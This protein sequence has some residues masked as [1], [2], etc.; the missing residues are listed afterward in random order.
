MKYTKLGHT[1]LDVSRICLGT[2]GFGRPESGM[3]PWAIDAQKSEKVVAKAL[4]LGI[5]FFDTANIYSHGDSERYLGAAL[6]KLAHRD[7]VVVATKVFYTPTNEPNQHGLSRK[8]IMTQID[9]SLERLDMDYIDLY[10]IH[11]WDYQTPIE[12]TMEALHDLVKAG[13]VRYIGASAMFA[14]QLE[15]AQNIAEKHNWTKFVSM[16]NHYNLLYREDERELIPYCE[17]QDIA[18]TPYS[19][20][21]SGRLARQW[22]ADTLRFKTDQPAKEKYD[23]DKEKDMPI[24]RRVGEVAEKYDVPQAQVALSWLLH[25]PQVAAPIVGAT[26]P[27]HLQ[28]SVAAVDLELAEEDLNYLAEAYTPHRVVG[29]LTPE[30]RNFTR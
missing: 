4:E 19:P 27:D 10:I 6:K 18:L 25:Q 13:K 16:Q 29:P 5:N 2:M 30:D 1:G 20:L 17:D 3:F 24:I 7:Q 21:A 28:S 8:A 23:A 26:N 22:S 14:W 11:R 15:K 9:Q 12:E